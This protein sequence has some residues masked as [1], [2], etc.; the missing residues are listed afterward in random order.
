MTVIPPG[1][2][3]DVD[4]GEL[5]TLDTAVDVEGGAVR[6]TVR[7]ETGDGRLDGRRG[8]LPLDLRSNA[9]YY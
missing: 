3:V 6:C 8:K 5:E 9:L 1:A 7:G 4:V 2:V